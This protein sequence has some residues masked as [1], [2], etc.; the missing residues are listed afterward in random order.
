MKISF[1]FNV[2]WIT[3]FCKVSILITSYALINRLLAKYH[4]RNY[5]KEK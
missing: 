5:I 3:I 1:G 4:S 2:Y